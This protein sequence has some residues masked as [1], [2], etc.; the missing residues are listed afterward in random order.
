M[1]NI[2][3][4]EYAERLTP[5]LVRAFAEIERIAREPWP[6]SGDDGRP[7]GN[8]GDEQRQRDQA[9]DVDGDEADDLHGGSS[10]SGPAR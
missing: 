8:R 7:Q 10:G 2:V 9:G 4:T 3:A 1:S 6:S 5:S